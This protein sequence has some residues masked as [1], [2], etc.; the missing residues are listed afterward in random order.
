MTHLSIARAKE[1]KRSFSRV[2]ALYPGVS[3]TPFVTVRHARVYEFNDREG[4]KK[5]RKGER[6][7][8]IDGGKKK[9]I[10]EQSFRRDRRLIRSSRTYLPTYLPPR[11]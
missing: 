8:N 10:N 4:G 7:K 6:E 9:T 2:F 1:A 11:Y 5:K 3:E